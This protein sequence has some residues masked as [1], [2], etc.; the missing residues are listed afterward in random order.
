MWNVEAREEWRWQGENKSVDYITLHLP[1][2]TAV[3]GFHQQL[4]GQ[5]YELRS[6][7]DGIYPVPEARDNYKIYLMV[8]YQPSGQAKRAEIYKEALKYRTRYKDVPITLEAT[9][10]HMKKDLI[11]AFQ[12]ETSNGIPG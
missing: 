10:K 2:N 11:A 8:T 3:E 9:V 1:E 7:L 4:S 5:F 6:W 12:K